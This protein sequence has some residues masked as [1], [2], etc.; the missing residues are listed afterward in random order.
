MYKVLWQNDLFLLQNETPSKRKPP[1]FFNAVG[2]FLYKVWIVQYGFPK[3][4]FG[5][6]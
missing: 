4:V 6:N 5:D 1:K 2:N 3:F